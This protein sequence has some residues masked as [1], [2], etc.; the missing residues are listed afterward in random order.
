M[1]LSNKQLTFYYEVCSRKGKAPKD[2]SSMTPFQLS[3][4]IEHMLTLPN[5]ASE[6]QENTLRTMLK[7]LVD[8]G[9]PNVR[10]PGDKFWS[11]FE[12]W[13]AT[14]ASKWIEDAQAIR[15]K[16]FDVLPATEQQIERLSLMYLFPEVEW[17]SIT[18]QKQEIHE[19]W[20]CDDEDDKMRYKKEKITY[21]EETV[22]QRKIY[23]DEERDG[24]QLWRYMDD[25][26][27]KSELKKLT[28]QQASGLLD[29]YS[30]AFTA[31]ERTRITRGQKT[32]IRQIENRLASIYTP[33]EVTAY[34]LD[35][36]FNLG[37]FG[38]TNV[39]EDVPFQNN[40]KKVDNWNPRAYEP[41]KEQQ[42]DMMSREEADV[43]IRQLRKELQDGEL[44]NVGG[45]QNLD[46][47]EY[48]IEEARTAKNEADA[49][50]KEFKELNN[51]LYGLSDIVGV[52]FEVI[53]TTTDNAGNV[54][55]MVTTPDSL[56]HDALQVF[57]DTKL[58]IKVGGK[59][60]ETG[61]GTTQE[62]KD[63]LRA[64]ITDFVKEAI[65]GKSI[66]F[67]GIMAL[68]DRSEI[69]NEILDEIIL[70][71]DFAVELLKLQ[72]SQF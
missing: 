57:F 18:R 19:Y 2:T 46:Y 69:A 8:A 50:T 33:K 4:E 43:Y 54:V 9:I 29:K 36:P 6:A 48:G 24:V 3:Q 71:P 47:A 12:M 13:N 62:R 7:E 31:W 67:D 53:D 68:A 26:E 27:F 25:K 21:T 45:A 61:A 11:N 1:A 38:D 17:E 49:R 14:T 63:E 35:Q 44:R 40:T 5:R 41:L 60:V 39:S 70:D 72:R 30:G 59:V 42:L 66:K 10:V 28:H 56:R 65:R 20:E 23:L 64:Q 15:A 55:K 16:H 34:D 58:H 52:A 51:F 32:Q 37:D 22:I